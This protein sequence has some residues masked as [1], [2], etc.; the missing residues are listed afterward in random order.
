MSLQLYR[1]E[2]ARQRSA[3]AASPLQNVRER[4][5]RAAKA[6]DALAD[7]TEI[8]DTARAKAASEKLIAMSNERPNRGLVALT[9]DDT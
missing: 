8:A 6:W 5:E 4:C 1:G 9:Q 2:A 7:R 3:A